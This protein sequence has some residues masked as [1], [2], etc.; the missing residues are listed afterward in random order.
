[1]SNI[2]A[3]LDGIVARVKSQVGRDL[4]AAIR[5]TAGAIA[6][7][8]RI[9]MVVGGSA[10]PIVGQAISAVQSRSGGL[11]AADFTFSNPAVG[12]Y[13]IIWS[14]GVIP[15]AA[16]VALVGTANSPGSAGGTNQISV[17][18]ARNNGAA[19]SGLEGITVRI[20]EAVAAGALPVPSNAIVSLLI[21]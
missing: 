2:T 16:I 7:V 15:P 18:V 12:V 21:G 14:N 5:Q 20:F 1:M 11:A 17:N 3:G 19:G 10:F 6:P 8:Q 9:S 4:V 13:N